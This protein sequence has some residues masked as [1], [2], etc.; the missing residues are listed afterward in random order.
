MLEAYLIRTESDFKMQ[1]SGKCLWLLGYSPHRPTVYILTGV[2]STHNSL[3]A[4]RKITPSRR[5]SIVYLQHCS[6]D[7]CRQNVVAVSHVF[8]GQSNVFE[9]VSTDI[10][11]L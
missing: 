4:L 7:Y 8:P 1:K 5:C 9:E 3:Q 11:V 10:D 6:Y 2:Y